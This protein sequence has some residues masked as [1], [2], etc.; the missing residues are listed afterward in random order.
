VI[1]FDGSGRQGSDTVTLRGIAAQAS[2]AS[3]NHCVSLL[4]TGGSWA[5]ATAYPDVILEFSDGTF[6]TLEGAFPASATGTLAYN[7][8]SA[9]D[10]AALSFSLPCPAKADA[11]RANLLLA[12][13]AECDLVLYSG[14]TA[15]QS[16][17]VTYRQ[18]V[19]NV[20]SRVVEVPIPET[21]I[22]ANT[23][24]YVAVKPTTANNVTVTTHDVDDANHWTCH[25]GGASVAY[26]TRADA[27]AW[28]ATATRRM[29]AGV[30]LTAFDDGTGSGGGGGL[31]VL[32][33]SV[34]R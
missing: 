21:E 9:A 14:T 8:G 1:E 4:Y 22:A 28:S 17:S 23:T 10:E 27:G 3:P 31:P 33:G 25:Q 26:A 7:T 20:G 34:V 16:V 30:R 15:L 5:Q 19:N 2:A 18:V 6:G 24:H 11:I 29:W 12:A 13:S 32:G